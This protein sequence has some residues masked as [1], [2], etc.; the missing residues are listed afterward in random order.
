MEY[1]FLI[2]AIIFVGDAL[3]TLIDGPAGHY[4]ELRRV[5]AM[6]HFDALPKTP[7]GRL[8]VSTI[9]GGLFSYMTY[10]FW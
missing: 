4:K 3:I 5:E 1:I 10:H 6:G 8:L 9:V 7:L 2:L